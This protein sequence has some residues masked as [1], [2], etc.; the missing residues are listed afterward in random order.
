MS[1]K[2]KDPVL[3]WRV[4]CLLS[5]ALK[6]RCSKYEHEQGSCTVASA[7]FPV[8]LLPAAP[9][10]R[11]QCTSV[12]FAQCGQM[13]E[14]GARSCVQC[15]RKV[16]KNVLA[17]RGVPLSKCMKRNLLTELFT[18]QMC[19]ESWWTSC[20]AVGIFDQDHFNYP[21]CIPV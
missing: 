16:Q 11:L 5:A 3:L 12:A 13:I 1:K 21:G 17:D 7:V 19:A 18:E 10:V 9:L 14:T 15:L 2:N 8:V 20:D 6:L 4:Q